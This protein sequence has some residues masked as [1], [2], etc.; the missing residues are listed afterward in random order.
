MHKLCRTEQ[1]LLG[2]L[3]LADPLK[4]VTFPK[5]KKL[6]KTVDSLSQVPLASNPLLNWPK[7]GQRLAVASS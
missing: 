7:R 3:D 1:L 2:E 6:V 4:G 5:Q